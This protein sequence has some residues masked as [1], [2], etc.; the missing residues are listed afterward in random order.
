MFSTS[1]KQKLARIVLA[2]GAACVFPFAAAHAQDAATVGKQV[3]SEACAVCHGA[4]GHGDG[5]FAQYLNVKPS[6]LTVLAKNNHGVFPFLEVYHVVDGRTG[7]RGHGGGDMPIWGNVFS[8]ELGETGSIY[9]SVLYTR[10]KVISV[11]DYV[12]SLQTK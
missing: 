2:C 6:D 9:G 5:E 4:N 11:V 8:R 7:V 3:Y 1:L 12:Q 10:A